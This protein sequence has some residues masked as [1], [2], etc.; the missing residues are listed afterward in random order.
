MSRIS[1]VNGHYKCH[2]DAQVHIDERGMHFSDGVYEVIFFL[3]GRL[4]C[5]D[6]HL[7]RLAFSL[8]EISLKSPVSLSVLRS[9]VLEV[10]RLNHMTTGAVYIQVT[11][12]SAPRAHAFP[13]ITNPSLIVSVKRAPFVLENG[14]PKPGSVITL[15]DER[16]ARPD[17][18]SI[19]L[20]P[21]A[22]AKQAAT[23]KGAFE[24]ILYRED[25]VIT[26]GSSSNLWIVDNDGQV[27]TPPADRHILN[28]ITRQI[29]LKLCHHNGIRAVESAIT[30]DTLMRAQEIFL[31]GTTTFI[32]PINTIDDKVIKNHSFPVTEHIANLY[33]NFCLLNTTQNRVETAIQ[34]SNLLR[35]CS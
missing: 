8:R 30:R 7:D 35:L 16:W 10:I 29:I 17:I 18:K 19:C 32:K 5:L 23:E 28:G 22:L 34:S 13:K 24:A 27:V 12:G 20:L 9:I 25:G 26:E 2:R 4:I 3:K 1:Y 11:R 31:T 6:E 33:K 21:N 15:P 14:L